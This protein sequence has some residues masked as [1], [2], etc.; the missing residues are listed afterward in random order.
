MTQEYISG[1]LTEEIRNIYFNSK[2]VSIDTETLGLNH[3]RDRLCLVQLCNEDGFVTL[4]KITSKNTPKLKE[5]LENPNSIKLFHFAR[6]DMGIL[7][8][9]LNISVNN[10][11]CTKIASKIAR[12][13][14][15]KHGLKNLVLDLLG[16]ELDKTSQT[17][18]WGAD[19]LS[20][21]QLDYAASD[22]I[23]LVKLREKLELML[24]RENRKSFSDESMKFLPTLVKLDLN[25]WSENIFSH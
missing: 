2:F 12:T 14:T 5:I 4:L 13:F 18:D 24:E 15:D 8:K 22:V 11:Y 16:V 7:Y 20:K 3:N 6:F 25:G 9:Y 17:T 21:K 23:Y 1:D 19:E 10:V